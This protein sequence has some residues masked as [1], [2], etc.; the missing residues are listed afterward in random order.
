MTD[1]GPALELGSGTQRLILEAS[2]FYPKGGGQV[3][4][5]GLDP[6]PRRRIRRRRHAAWTAAGMSCT[7]GDV[8]GELHPVGELARA[9]V[10]AR[11][12]GR[13][14]RHHT[15]THL[16]HRALKDVLGEGTS[17][18]GSYVGPDQL[19]FDFN[20]PRALRRGPSSRPSRE[21]INE[22]SMDDLPV[23][24]EIVP[25]D[26]ARQM[27]AIMMFGEKYG[28]EVRVV[29][30]G[31][32]SRELCGGT[33]TH[34]SGELGAVVI[35]SES[36]IG[37][38]KRRIVAYAGQAALAYLNAAAARCWRASTNGSARAAPTSVL[39][40]V[41]ALLAEM[42]PCAASSS[43]VSSS[44]PTTPLAPWPRRR[45]ISVGQGGGRL[46]G[47]RVWRR[48]GRAGR[49]GAR[50]P[51]RVSSSSAGRQDGRIP[52][53]AG[54][55][56]DLTERLHAGTLIKEVATRAGGGGGGNRPGF[57]RGRAQTLQN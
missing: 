40:R 52:L 13:S 17:Q 26:Q 27:G 21:I 55:T 2:P 6:Q 37:S 1:S 46:G 15:A 38:G 24:W 18:Q 56:R 53:V 44:R 9:E 23:H 28:D 11:R 25:I 35:A 39:S 31:D 41:D 7:S 57:A 32:Y 36:G 22:R 45:A 16:L 47:R 51:A 50:R 10:D 42:E 20:H 19:R 29:S 12:R 14:R 34:H 33:H 30:I 8:E 4:D 54:V 5:T 43:G 49:R 48:P 3:G